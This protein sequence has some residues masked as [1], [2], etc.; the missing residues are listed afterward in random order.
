ML[1][2]KLSLNYSDVYTIGDDIN[3]IDMIK[4]YNGY[5]LNTAINEVKQASQKNYNTLSEFIYSIIDN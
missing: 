1:I 5:S 4:K 2:S 3:D